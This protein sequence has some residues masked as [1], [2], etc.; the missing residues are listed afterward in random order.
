MKIIKESTLI[1]LYKSTIVNF[2]TTKR[3]YATDTIKFTEMKWN[4]FLGFKT[5]NITGLAQNEGR[6]YNSTIV[7]KNVK[8]HINNTGGLI[9]LVSKEG[10]QY[11]LEPLAENDVVLRCNCGDFHW[12]MKFADYLDKSLQGPNRKRYEAKINPGLA[13]PNN[14][15]GICKHLMVMMEVLEKSN[16]I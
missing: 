6:E 14:S 9:A 7:F 5:L 4:T 16:L 1:E 12:R 2:P 11:L 13:N 8:Y 10:R 15:P 3:Q